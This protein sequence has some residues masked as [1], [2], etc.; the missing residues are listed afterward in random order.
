[1]Y[2]R[3]DRRG[4]GTGPVEAQ[5]PWIQHKTRK[6]LARRNGVRRPR[7]V[8]DEKEHILILSRERPKVLDGNV[9]EGGG[10]GALGGKGET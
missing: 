2:T 8:T 5:K 1:M 3:T 7:P 9:E 4:G 10:A 6:K